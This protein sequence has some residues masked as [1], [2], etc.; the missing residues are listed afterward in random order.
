MIPGFNFSVISVLLI[1][2]LKGNPL[3]SPYSRWVSKQTQPS[4]GA[5]HTLAIVMMSGLTPLYSEAKYFP[6]L[7]KPV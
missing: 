3:A 1:I 7:P 2:P 5:I 4:V 6:V